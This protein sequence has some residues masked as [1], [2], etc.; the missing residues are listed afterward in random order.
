[1]GTGKARLGQI[2]GDHRRAGGAG[3]LQR[4]GRLALD[5]GLHGAGGLGERIA[6]RVHSLAQ[7][8]PAHARNAQRGAE[9]ARRGGTEEADGAF[10]GDAEARRH[11]HRADQSRQ[12]IRTRNRARLSFAGQRCADHRHGMDHGRFV[13]AIIFLAVDLE[14]VHKGG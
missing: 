5:M 7:A 9:Q 3:D 11:I 10:R 6:Q 8:R 2:I 13:H 1:M 14:T 4:Q 12:I